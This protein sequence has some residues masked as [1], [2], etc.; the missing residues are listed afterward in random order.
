MSLKT[1]LSVL[2]ISTPVLAFV[3]VG[4]LLGK[5][6]TGEQTFQHLRVFEDVVQLVMNHYVGE[7]K[8]D[9]AMDGA[10]RGLADGLDPDSAYLDAQQVRS[11]ESSAA[12]PDGDVGIEFTRQY[13][14][15]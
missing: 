12:P 14:P 11:L 7:V 5:E 10:M 1:R 2:L 13:Y 9:R 15:G 3:I 6:A 4:G 8:P